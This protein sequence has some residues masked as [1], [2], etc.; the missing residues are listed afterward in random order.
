MD[1]SSVAA[2]VAPSDEV[3]PG[4]GVTE[5]WRLGG[6]EPLALEYAA[7]GAHAS[8]AGEGEL[9]AVVDGAGPRPIAVEV[10][11]LYELAE[12]PRHGRHRLELAVGPGVELYSVS[13]SPGVP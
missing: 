13:F 9:R 3:L 2:G 7:G 12:H 4:G 1:G 8:V 5:P 10:P 6:G 11:G